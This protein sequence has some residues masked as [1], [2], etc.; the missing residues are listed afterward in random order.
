MQASMLDIFTRQGYELV[1]NSDSEKF[2]KSAFM[3]KIY[4][5]RFKFKE[6]KLEL[7]IQIL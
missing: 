4:F 7:I 5:S 6:D 2:G 1:S 3:K